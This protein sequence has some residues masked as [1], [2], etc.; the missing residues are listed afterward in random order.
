LKRQLADYELLAEM[1][2]M[3]SNVVV[4]VYIIGDSAFKFAPNLMKPYPYSTEQSLVE[5]NFNYKLSKCRRVV[6]NA[7]GQLKARFRRI[8]KGIDNNIG[9]AN[10]ILKSCCTLHNFLNDRDDDINLAWIQ[11]QE[12]FDHARESPDEIFMLHDNDADASAI[13]RAI[14]SYTS[15]YFF[16][17]T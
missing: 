2:T 13:R 11:D 4:P 17:I 9:N 14:A 15:K 7:F 8:G 3:L 12:R 1:S 10:I 16:L 5:K 6:E